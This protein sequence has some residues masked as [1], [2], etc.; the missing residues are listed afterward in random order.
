LQTDREKIRLIASDWVK[1]LLP[2]WEK[3]LVLYALLYADLALFYEI[4]HA[5]DD[6]SSSLG[7]PLGMRSP[8]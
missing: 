6:A 4:L 2:V 7:M 3:P 5:C 8:S 1:P